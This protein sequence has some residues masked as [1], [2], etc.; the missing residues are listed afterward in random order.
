MLIPLPEH[1]E[2]GG[3]LAGITA[4]LVERTEKKALYLRSDG[5]Y[6]AFKIRIKTLSTCKNNV[7]T[8][9]EDTYEE[10]PGN[11]AFGDYAWCGKRFIREIYDNITFK[12]NAVQSKNSNAE[13]LT[14]R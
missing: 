2:F 13:G 12:T 3:Q 14:E 5:Y 1:V 4:D 11:E 8:K 7:W 10:Y 9:T 6:E